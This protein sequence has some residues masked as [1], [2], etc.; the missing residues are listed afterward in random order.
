MFGM[1]YL[2]AYRHRVPLGLTPREIFDVKAAA[3]SHMVSVTIGLPA[4]SVALA[5]PGLSPM[6]SGFCY[7]L[8]GRAHWLYGTTVRRRRQARAERVPVA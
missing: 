3:G 7:F 1:L 2:R 4:M 6:F 8:M 5:R